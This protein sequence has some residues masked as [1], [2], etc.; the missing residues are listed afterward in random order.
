[1]T[2]T[3]YLSVEAI[4]EFRPKLAESS[5]ADADTDVDAVALTELRSR[6]V[7]R[8]G[9][10]IGRMVEAFGLKRFYKND[11]RVSRGRKHACGQ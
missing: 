8:S 7:I 6:A 10:S 2:L 1:M 9:L 5:E 11:D 3:D 4:A